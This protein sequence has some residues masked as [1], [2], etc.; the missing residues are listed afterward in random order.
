MKNFTDT[1]IESMLEENYSSQAASSENDRLS[2]EKAYKDELVNGPKKTI[3]T[4]DGRTFQIGVGSFD[5]ENMHKA[6]DDYYEK[7]N[8]LKLFDDTGK[9]INRGTYGEIK[10]LNKTDSAVKALFK[11]W[12]TQFK[13]ELE[14]TADKK[15][16]EYNYNQAVKKASTAA[17]IQINSVNTTAATDKAET[18]ANKAKIESIEKEVAEKTADEFKKLFAKEWEALLEEYT[19]EERKK[20]E[21]QTEPKFAWQTTTI[22][23]LA[24]DITN[25]IDDIDISIG[26]HDF[27]FT[28]VNKQE[29]ADIISETLKEN[30]TKIKERL[31]KLKG[32]ALTAHYL[33]KNYETYLKRPESKIIADKFDFL[34]YLDQ[35]A[36]K[37]YWARIKNLAGNKVMFLT[38][39]DKNNTTRLNEKFRLVAMHGKVEAI[40]GTSYTSKRWFDYFDDTYSPELIKKFK[41]ETEN[42]PFKNGTTGIAI[43]EVTDDYKK[44]FTKKARCLYELDTSD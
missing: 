21:I 1:L 5:L 41:V 7:N 25:I 26:E 36:D 9:L 37:L 11:L 33:S 24:I 42:Q 18:E 35:F 17:G 22:T 19:E 30:E 20:I 6:Y 43:T 29:I 14:F 2:A 12:G 27:L 28:V 32:L 23:A 39:E 4:A 34:V 10:N 8:L 40:N 3:T 31:T 15:A 38:G 16:R 44:F 13:G